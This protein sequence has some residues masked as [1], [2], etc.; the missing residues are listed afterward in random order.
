MRFKLPLSL[1]AKV[2]SCIGTFALMASAWANAEAISVSGT[3]TDP[4][5]DVL[6][7]VTVSVKGDPTNG[8]ATDFDGQYS[9]KN[10]PSD[11]S[12]IFSY[13]GFGSLEEK[14]NGRTTR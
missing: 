2:L 11:G 8:T 3:V 7:G 10:V 5:G 14:V 9:L 13:V 4:T 1:R 6:I 12:L